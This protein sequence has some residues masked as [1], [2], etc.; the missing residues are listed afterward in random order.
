[1][2]KYIYD[3]PVMVFNT[4]VADHWRGET[5]AVSET[6]ARCNLA[7]QF[8]RQNNKVTNAK[9]TLPGKLKLVV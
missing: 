9:I 1:M 8:K 6:K 3:G 4:C 2:N 7:Y 5:M